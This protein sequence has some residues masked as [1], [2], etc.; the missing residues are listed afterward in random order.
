MPASQYGP[1]LA[2][3]YLAGEQILN[4]RANRKAAQAEAERQGRTNRLLDRYASGDKSAKDELLLANPEL[5]KKYADAIG[6]MDENERDRVK[7]MSEGMAKHAY[8][9]MNSGNPESEWARLYQN[10]PSEVQAE[11]GE[12]YDPAKV[13]EMYYNGMTVKEIIEN[14]KK[15]TVGS[16]DMLFRH[17]RKIGEATSG[18]MQRKFIDVGEKAKGRVNALE[19]AKLRGKGD[20][21]TKILY[22]I[23]KTGLDTGD[24]PEA[25]VRLADK[26]MMDE[27][28]SMSAAIEKAQ[29]K[30]VH[31]EK[32]LSK[33]QWQK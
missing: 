19:V 2:E 22:Y 17:G 26:I 15:V 4:S 6:K 12:R 20:N 32:N 9:I 25:F 27:G 13:K 7:A 24:S 31:K 30:L 10:A 1:N 16:K 18:A 29:Q 28:L 23:D 11:M 33:I 14:P 5:M 8:L 3:T 21:A